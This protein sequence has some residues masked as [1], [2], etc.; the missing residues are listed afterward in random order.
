M[1]SW[2]VETALILMVVLVILAVLAFMVVRAIIYALYYDQK[3]KKCLVRSATPKDNAML[4]LWA[5]LLMTQHTAVAH[6]VS[7]SREEFSKVTEEAAKVYLR[8]AGD[9]CLDETYKALKYT[10]DEALNDSM[11]YLSNASWPD[12]FLDS[13]VMMVEELF[14]AYVDD[15]FYTTMENLLDN[16]F[17]KPRER[18]RDYKNELKNCLVE[19]SSPRDKAML[20]LWLGLRMTEHVAVAS[21]VNISREE[22]SQI[23]QE[24]GKVYLHLTCEMCLAEA[25]NVLK[26]EGNEAFN[27]S[28]QYLEEV[29]QQEFLSDPGIRNALELFSSYRSK[30]NDLLREKAKSEK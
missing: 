19:W 24:A 9:L 7:I 8:L 26:F 15:R 28:F 2:Q 25:V 14:H 30:I 21:T 12:K 6:M 22:I 23:I 1:E 10:G 27:D 29:S 4:A 18:G 13:G 11:Q 5:G 3:L 17:D 20:S 16:S